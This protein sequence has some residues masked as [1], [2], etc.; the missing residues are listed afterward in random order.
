MTTTI[1]TLSQYCDQQ[2]TPANFLC[3]LHI[4]SKLDVV[5]ERKVNITAG[6]V[7]NKYFLL[8]LLKTVKK[9]FK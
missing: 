7:L 5:K 4:L 8:T 6:A 9:A 3:M 2:Y 1:K